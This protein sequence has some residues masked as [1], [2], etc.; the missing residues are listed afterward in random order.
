LSRIAKGKK[1]GGPQLL[2][3]LLLLK[4]VIDL[5]RKISLYED[6]EA[7]KQ[8]LDVAR[9]L[10]YPSHQIAAMS[11]NEIKLSKKKA[12]VS[13]AGTVAGDALKVVELGGQPGDAP[14]K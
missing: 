14:P 4:E 10:V 6:V 11:L 2:A 8:R 1:N 7:A 3:G 13:S 12:R 5:R 9:G